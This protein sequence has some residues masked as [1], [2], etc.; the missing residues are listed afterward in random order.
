MIPTSGLVGRL[1]RVMRMDS[2]VYSEIQADPGTL[3]Q[4]FVVVLG[5]AVLIGVGQGSP[6]AV[7]LGIAGA[8]GSWG[9]STLLI[10]LAGTLVSES[11]AVYSELLRC[12]GFAFAWNSLGIAASLPWIGGLAEWAG[13]LL[14]TGSLFLAARAVFSLS[15]ARTGVMCALAVGLPLLVALAAGAREV[16]G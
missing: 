10:W 12:A 13:L 11:E 5:T 8:L 9:L 14:W 4:A 6:A 1:E 3:P 2:S 7:F 15:P 16:G